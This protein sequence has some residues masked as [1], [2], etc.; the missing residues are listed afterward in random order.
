M[1]DRDPEGGRGLFRLV[2]SDFSG[3]EALLCFR[4]GVDDSGF[5]ASGSAAGR[6]G[7]GGEEGG[8]ELLV[9]GE[10]ELDALAVGGEGFGAVAAF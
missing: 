10:E 6:G 7:G 2:W 5:G 3:S 9:E 8:G 1:F 4:P